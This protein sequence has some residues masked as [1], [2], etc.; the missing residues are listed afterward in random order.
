MRGR[1]SVS[2]TPGATAIAY[3]LEAERKLIVALDLPDPAE[4]RDAWQALALSQAVCKVGLELIMAGGLELAKSLAADG[5]PVFV[6]AK[7]LDIANTVERAT[8]R[9]ADLGVSFL[10]VH[11]PDRATAEAAARGREGRALKLLGVTVLTSLTEASLKQQGVAGAPGEIALRRAAFAADAGFDGVVSSPLEAR[12]LKRAFKDRLL[13]VC[14]G[15]RPDGGSA[16]RGDDQQRVATPAEALLAGAD[17]IV[18]GRPILAAPDP[19]AAA[20]QI[21]VEMA[22]ALESTDRKQRQLPA[23]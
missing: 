9:V 18:V 10:T 19:A 20:R 16:V 5:V 21:L 17:Y 1:Q 6:D 14:P 2:V 15:V 11:T 4:A 23:G 8:A 7:L 22:A 12:S 13:V 3:D